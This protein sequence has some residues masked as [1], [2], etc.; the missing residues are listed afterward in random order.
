MGNKLVA[1]PY[2]HLHLDTDKDQVK[3]VM[4]GANK[5]ALKAMPDVTYSG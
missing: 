2:D 1:V 4:P 3:I 5:E